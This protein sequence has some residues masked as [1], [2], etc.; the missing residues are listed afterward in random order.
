LKGWYELYNR[1]DG[2]IR[3]LGRE[4]AVPVVDN[5]EL[6][7]AANRHRFFVDVAHLTD[8]GNG[9]LARNVFD[10]MKDHKRLAGGP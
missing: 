3:E 10:T 9:I 6:F 5:R 4:C 7:P 1:Y 2:V 8:E